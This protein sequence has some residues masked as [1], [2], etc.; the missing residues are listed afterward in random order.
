MY[1]WLV[2]EIEEAENSGVEVRVDGIHYSLDN[3]DKLKQVMENNYYMK[4]YTGDEHGRIVQI[5]F[6]RII[7]V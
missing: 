4:S 2:S 7:S 1:S 5:D 6:E 3:V